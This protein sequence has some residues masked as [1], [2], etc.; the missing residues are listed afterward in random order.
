MDFLFSQK[1]GAYSGKGN[2]IEAGVGFFK[3]IGKHFV[4]ETYGGFGQGSVT[5][6]SRIGR[7]TFKLSRYFIQPSI[8]FTTPWFD[9]AASARFCELSYNQLDS[10]K[11]ISTD[12]TELDYIT[13]NKTSLLFEPALTIRGGWKYIKCQM[14]LGLS[15][16]LTN[17]DFQQEVFNFNLGVYV[18]ISDKYKTKI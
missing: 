4:F 9:I 8:G 7:S 11:T 10:G 14:Q 13:D 17:P 18:A 2:L 15:Q 16:N 12:K 6:N 3:P 5:N 1:K